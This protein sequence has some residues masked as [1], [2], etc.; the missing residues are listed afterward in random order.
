[1]ESA[2][3]D[4]SVYDVLWQESGTCKDPEDGAWAWGAI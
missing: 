1:M 2:G 3:G 4:G